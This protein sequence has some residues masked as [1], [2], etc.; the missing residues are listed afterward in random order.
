M[1]QQFKIMKRILIL[2]LMIFAM[3]AKGQVYQVMPQYGYQAPR[4]MFDS[5]LQI[6]TFCGVPTLKSL[7]GVNKK[8]AI[9]F[10]SC[11]NR[12][13][14]YNPKTLT[15]SQVTGGGG[16]SG[17][18]SL[19]RVSDSIFARKDGTFYFQYKDSIGSGGGGS[20]SDTAK[21][22]IAQVRNL[23]ATTLQIGEVVYLKGSTG[24]TASVK[25][26]S[27]RDD[28]TSSRTLGVVRASIAPNATGFVTTQGQVEK[29]NL[30]SYAEGDIL[31]LD[32]IAGGVTKIKPIAPFHGVFIG[33]VERANNG[34]GIAYIKPQNGYEL[35]E[36]HDVKITSLLNNQILVYS[37]TQ[38]VW[39]NRN[40]LS[41]LPTYTPTIVPYANGSGVLTGAVADMTY[42]SNALTIGGVA[43]IGTEHAL[44]IN[45]GRASIYGN[46]NGMRLNVGSGTTGLVDASKTFSFFN[47]GTRYAYITSIGSGALGQ[48]APF[49]HKFIYDSADIYIPR[50]ASGSDLMAVI[51]AS[52]GKLKAQSIPSGV[53]PILDS[54]VSKGNVVSAGKTIIMNDN[55][56]NTALQISPS[57]LG[58]GKG[59]GTQD[60]IS[61]SNNSGAR[62]FRLP[63]RTTNATLDTL[64]TMFDIRNLPVQDSGVGTLQQVLTRGKTYSFTD[65]HYPSTLTLGNYNS[66]LVNGLF[67]TNTN[68]NTANIYLY[69]DARLQLNNY[70]SNWGTYI[71]VSNGVRLQEVV[72]SNVVFTFMKNNEI[73][74]AKYE[75]TDNNLN[76][77]KP[78]SY[79]PDNQNKTTHR[80]RAYDNAESIS[81]DTLASTRDI[82]NAIPYKTFSATY[83]AGTSG[84]AN[85]VNLFQSEGFGIISTLT[86]TGSVY[87]LDCTGC[88]PADKTF[89]SQPSFGYNIVNDEQSCN[90][91]RISD[92]Q[93]ELKIFNSSKGTS[94]GFDNLMLEI[95][96]Y[97]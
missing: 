81:E 73:G 80:L 6:P 31:W 38:K 34:N 53:T 11:N 37:D 76:V 30:G 91:K 26:A 84:D 24:N 2:F 88:F 45:G 71:D 54:V 51:E 20:G 32:S 42:G 39:K 89:I 17:I 57:Y 86:Q 78:Y 19:K 93:I 13:Y 72:N 27:N 55:A 46:F 14:T 97:N 21:V 82:R 87:T 41:V 7:V 94:L 43:P 59:G 52:T 48:D 40:I 65:L 15:W 95:K 16:A 90:I 62:E 29:M 70:N 8:S 25:R 49:T 74:F 75:T 58:F 92:N 9:A 4:M 56:N 67:L 50:L 64:A 44:Q 10:D 85:L 83:T 22:V 69:P 36:I 28:T 18:D 35:E 1:F 66:A 47:K 33:I 5:T 61:L 96:V 12:F 79:T 23:E 3:G 60:K 68:A 77:I 63:Y